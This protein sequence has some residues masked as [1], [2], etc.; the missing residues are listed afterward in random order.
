[1]LYGSAHSEAVSYKGVLYCQEAQKQRGDSESL[2]C[3]HTSINRRL[4]VRKLCS[5]APRGV[6]LRGANVI[7]TPVPPR[8][9]DTSSSSDQAMSLGRM[10]HFRSS[11]SRATIL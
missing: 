10:D 6:H 11:R 7:Y 9:V 5:N 2:S 1:M 4:S 3:S 8:S